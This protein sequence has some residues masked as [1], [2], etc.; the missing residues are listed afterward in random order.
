LKN[1]APTSA[2]LANQAGCSRLGPGELMVVHRRAAA[3]MLWDCSLAQSCESAIEGGFQMLP[4]EPPRSGQMGFLYVPPFRV[5]GISIAGEQTCV[6]VPELDV[7]FD[8]GLCPRIALTT[9][10]I[11]LSHGHMDHLAGLPYYFSQR[12]FQK[13]GVG[14]CVCPAAIAKPLITMMNAWI[15]LE[16][17]RT[18]FE[19]IGLEPDQQIEVKNNVFLRGIE[20]RHTVPALG[21]ALVERRSKLKPEFAE[22]PQEKLRELKAAGTEI[23]RMLEIPLVA[24]TGDTEFGP[25]LYREEFAS[26][27]IVITE[28]TF[29]EHDHKSRASIGKHMHINDIAQ[30][31]EVWKAEAVVLIHLSRRTNMATSRQALEKIVG[32]EQCQR[33]HFLMDYRANRSRYEAQMVEAGAEHADE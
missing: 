33:V 16:Q 7:T 20:M 31:L 4:K 19:I 1:F 15:P 28:C 22:Y 21:Y 17:Q 18:P 10:Y 27:R 12:V 14:K 26:A 29:L 25:N 13:I 3:D 30:L 9:P 2:H 24:Y 11:A 32:R 23:T 5:Q 6:Q 8:I